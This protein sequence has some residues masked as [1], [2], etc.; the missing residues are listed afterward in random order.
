MEWSLLHT[1]SWSVCRF[2][3]SQGH[4]CALC[5]GEVEFAG[6]QVH[7]TLRGFSFLELNVSHMLRVFGL[8]WDGIQGDSQ[9]SSYSERCLN[10]N[11]LSEALA[12][13]VTWSL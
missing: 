8:V 5:W 3:S 7:Y 4:Q 9:L 13:S 11:L 6:S 1:K 10:H 12:E 2:Y